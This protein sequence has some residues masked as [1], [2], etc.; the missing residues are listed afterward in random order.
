MKTKRFRRMAALAAAA[1]MCMAMPGMGA[2]ASTIIGGNVTVAPANIIISGTYN[3]LEYTSGSVLSC[4]GSTTVPSGYTAYVKVELQ[5]YDA[6]WSTI[7]TWTNQGGS[8]A[9]VD[10]LRA[11]DTDYHY[12]LKITHKAYDS[13]G[14]LIETITEYSNQV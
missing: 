10:E 12:K 5:Q 1:V 6:G 2:A 8:N 7:K 9:T 4:Y 14:T 13:N 3:G 11:V